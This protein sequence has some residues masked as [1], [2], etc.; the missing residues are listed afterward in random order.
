[1]THRERA[2]D[3]QQQRDGVPMTA[4]AQPA[5]PTKIN[6]AEREQDC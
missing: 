1:M 6:G 2:H 5:T 4:T 3:G